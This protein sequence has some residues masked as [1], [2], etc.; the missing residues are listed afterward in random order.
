MATRTNERGVLEWI[1]DDHARGLAAEDVAHA[2]ALQ[3]R[4]DQYGYLSPRDEQRYVAYVASA[5]DLLT[6]T[7]DYKDRPTDIPRPWR[8]P[9]VSD[10]DEPQPAKLTKEEA[11]ERAQAVWN[12]YKKITR[13]AIE[14][15]QS[16]HGVA[17]AQD[18]EQKTVSCRLDRE[19]GMYFVSGRGETVQFASLEAA[20]RECKRRVGLSIG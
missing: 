6:Q 9:A 1:S 12:V 19:L 15:K 17:T 10:D 8:S 11:R 4:L 14:T 16:L 3:R 20:E 5:T 13:G 7:G 18:T 2:E